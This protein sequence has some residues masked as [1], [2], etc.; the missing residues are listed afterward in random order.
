MAHP[1]HP[2]QV[3]QKPQ[4]KPAL[5]AERGWAAMVASQARAAEYH[6]A[7][8]AAAEAQA[9]PPSAAPVV[10]S[11]K[12]EGVGA[13]AAEVVA[14]AQK[15]TA[16]VFC[17]QSRWLPGCGVHPVIPVSTQHLCAETEFFQDLAGTSE[18]RSTVKCPS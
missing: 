12:H 4:A 1:V 16:A 10:D 17:C 14:L 15:A 13:V 9:K 11:R 3:Q 7:A 8:R 6:A 5:S 18:L 2:A